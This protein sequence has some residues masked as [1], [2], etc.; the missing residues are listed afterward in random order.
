MVDQVLTGGRRN[1]INVP[2]GVWAEMGTMFGT[3]VKDYPIPSGG[4]EETPES[5][6]DES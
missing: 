6:S 3:L 2:Q 5:A 1:R 4:E